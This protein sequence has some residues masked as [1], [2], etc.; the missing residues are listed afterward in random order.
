MRHPLFG[1]PG[2]PL[3]AR[4]Y[5]R[6]VDIPKLPPEAD[7][8]FRT[9]LQQ[10]AEML[11]VI[12][13]GLPVT[14]D[15]PWVVVD[16]A[17]AM[18]ESLKPALKAGFTVV[19]RLRR[20]AA[21][22]DLPLVLPPGTK[23]GR[24]RPPIYGKNALSL[25]KRAGQK[26]GW[27]CVRSRTASGREVVERFKTLVATWRPAGGVIRVVILKA[28]DDSWRAFLCSD[29]EASVES[30]VQA[31]HDRWTIQAN[32]RDLK[33]VERVGEVQLRRVWSN[34][35]AF[36][37][38]MWVHTLTESWAWKRSAEELSDR[39][40]SPWDDAARRPSHA[41]R[42]RAL[43]RAMW[44]EEYRQLGVPEPL[45]E[46]ILPLLDRITRLAG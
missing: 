7:V 24:G 16:G 2:L 28:E 33:Q 21:L 6:K 23:R 12:A 10:A 4:L 26:R 5:V 19:A 13:S 39:R 42:R 20:D 35:G 43:Q 18:R 11:R 9:K 22:F 8:T 36:H 14:D 40:V 37:L 45:G 15:R 46:K 44:R 30:I 32:Y 25:A 31:V 29:R 27:S 1:S 41:D 38:G 3:L 17:Y 34:V